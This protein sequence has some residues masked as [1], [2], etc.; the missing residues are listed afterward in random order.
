MKGCLNK[1]STGNW[2]AFLKNLHLW[3]IWYKRSFS[4]SQWRSL[5]I[6]TIHHIS[7]SQL[8]KCTSSSSTPAASLQVSHPL[9]SPP[10]AKRTF[11]A[12]TGSWQRMAQPGHQQITALLC[13]FTLSQL[14]VLTMIKIQDVDMHE[15]Y[16]WLQPHL[17][18]LEEDPLSCY[19]YDK[20]IRE[21]RRLGQAWMIINGWS[22]INSSQFLPSCWSI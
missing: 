1:I 21:W 4:T 5:C 11:I 22:V 20:L 7:K 2:L 10:R 17:G 16:S 14:Q 9:S 12:N 19:K 15:K 13:S 18:R 3:M 8:E 6:I